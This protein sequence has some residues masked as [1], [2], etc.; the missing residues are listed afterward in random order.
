MFRIV[1]WNNITPESVDLLHISCQLMLINALLMRVS[2]DLDG[3]QTL[4]LWMKI[5]RSLWIQLLSQ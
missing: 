2:L 1:I 3:Y 5:M 4:H